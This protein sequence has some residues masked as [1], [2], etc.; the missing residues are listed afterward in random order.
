MRVKHSRFLLLGLFFCAVANLWTPL[1][2][3]DVSPADRQT[4]SGLESFQRGDFEQAALNWTEASQ[5]YERAGEIRRQSEALV[6]LSQANQALG[7]YKEAGQKSRVSSQPSRKSRRSY[8]SSLCPRCARKSLHRHRSSR[9]G[10]QKFERG[11][12]DRKRS[13]QSG[14]FGHDPQ[15]FGKHASG[16]KKIPRS[17][18]RL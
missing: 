3:A 14:S 15:Q 18:R 6:Y 7:R 4:K 13:E 5:L 8:T 12:S 2:A 1:F 16:A 17:G 10:P 9:N 11:A